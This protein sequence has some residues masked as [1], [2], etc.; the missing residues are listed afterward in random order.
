M[1]TY[2]LQVLLEMRQRAEEDAKTAFAEAQKALR[3]E[4][5]KLQ[6]EEELLERMIADRKRRR[7]EYSRKLASGEMKVTDQSSANRFLE[8]MKEKEAEQKDRIEAQREQVRR[9]E[10]EVKKAQD[11][12][13][14]ATQELKALQKH[15]ENWETQIK[16]EMAAKEE[17]NLD[18]IG[19]VIFN[20][21]RK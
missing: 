20:Q 12:L 10:K 14:E 18:E 1:A 8:R 2:R 21:R 16:K 6:E 3:L 17:D 13:I 9:A 15:K 19:Q 11:A 5:K 4:E 7:E